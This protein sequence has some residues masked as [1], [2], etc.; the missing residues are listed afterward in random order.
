[1]AKLEVITVPESKDEKDV[2]YKYQKVLEDRSSS[3]A[4]LFKMEVLDVTLKLHFSRGAIVAA[5]GPN[6]DSMGVFASYGD[7]DDFINVIHPA[8]AQGLFSD[9]D[10][11][12]LILID[13]CLVKFYLCKKYFPQS[14]DFKMYYK[15]LSDVLAGIVSGDFRE[16]SIKFDIR[17]Y[18]DGKKLKKDQELAMIFYIMMKN[19]GVDFIFEH[20]DKIMQD[21]DIVKT[22]FTIYKKSFSELVK[23][24]KKD[25]LD[26]KRKLEEL[27]RNK[28][29]AQRDRAR[30]A[31]A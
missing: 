27:E 21:C 16:E 3:I 2:T 10:K 24:I 30:N 29:A 28:R 15:Y 12:M 11:Q 5:M 18:E 31:S 26:E 25:V 9:L 13:Y 22:V 17:M 19:S 7:C 6:G 23:V 20:L 1:M 4:K 8:A 14:T